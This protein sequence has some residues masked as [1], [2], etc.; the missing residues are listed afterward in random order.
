MGTTR[1]LCNS[2]LALGLIGVLGGISIGCSEAEDGNGNGDGNDDDNYV[3]CGVPETCVPPEPP[4]YAGNCAGCCQDD[5]CVSGEEL[6][7]CGT[8]GMAC[9]ACDDET[10]CS[11]GLCVD[12]SLEG[13]VIMDIAEGLEPG[14][15]LTIT[16]GELAI[17]LPDGYDFESFSEAY[18][19]RSRGNSSDSWGPVANWDP[20]TKQTYTIIDRTSAGEECDRVAFGGYNALTHSWMV[21]PLPV[22]SE[23]CEDG[24]FFG[25]PHV[26]S[27]WTLASEEGRFY[28][29]HSGDL[30]WFDIDTQSWDVIRDQGPQGGGI[31]YLPGTAEIFTLTGDGEVRAIDPV[32]M[33][34]RVVGEIADYDGDGTHIGGLYNRRRDEVMF[35]AGSLDYAV[36]DNE[37]ALIQTGKAP[38]AIRGSG[39][40]RHEVFFYDPISGNYLVANRDAGHLWEFSPD[41][42][43]WRMAWH[44]D[45]LEVPWA[46]YNGFL[47]APIDELGVI[48]WVDRQNQRVYRHQTVF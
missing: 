35:L 47:I 39:S 30:H 34:S 45:D 44:R 29:P 28:R 7:A 27:S 36:I 24:Q 31:A 40:W 25:R 23:S 32:E 1:S 22:P 10:L 12:P 18:L 6:G 14:E 9:V 3:A 2:L 46:N 26:Y 43:E 38:E 15:F 41:E 33:T 20:V 5:V 21:R 48:L 42:Q 4:C 17:G 16:E 11:A 19:Y 37:G 13:T 8:Q